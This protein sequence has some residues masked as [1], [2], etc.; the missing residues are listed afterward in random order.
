MCVKHL[1]VLQSDITYY[2]IS[3][4]FSF[5]AELHNHVVREEAQENVFPV[6]SLGVLMVRLHQIWS[7]CCQAK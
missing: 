5:S 7:H 4:F 2:Y 3:L 6:L 1:A